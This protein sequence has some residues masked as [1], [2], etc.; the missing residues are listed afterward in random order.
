MAVAERAD[1]APDRVSRPVETVSIVV[2]KERDGGRKERGREGARVETS[3]K[4]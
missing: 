2:E 3:Q 1:E 4:Q